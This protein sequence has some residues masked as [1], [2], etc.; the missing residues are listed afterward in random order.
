VGESLLMDGGRADG[1]DVIDLGVCYV[2]ANM[3]LLGN[4]GRTR[5]WHLWAL[6]IYLVL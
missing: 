2:W 3:G 6:T 1:A 5:S 4:D